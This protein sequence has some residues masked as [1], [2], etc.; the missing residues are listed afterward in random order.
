MR[1]GEGGRVSAGFHG[2]ENKRQERADRRLDELEKTLSDSSG[3]ST[4]PEAESK[5]PVSGPARAD[6]MLE[7]VR[8][9]TDE[10]TLTVERR[11]SPEEDAGSAKSAPAQ[12]PAPVNSESEFI[13]IV[14]K[15]DT[16][17]DIARKYLGDPFKYDELARLSRIKDPHWIYPNDLIRIVRKYPRTEVKTSP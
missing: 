16:L 5:V 8:V 1:P 2:K 13:H 9:E 10:F 12:S 11:N 7:V 14:V 15:G 6:E 17:W 3:I 4:S